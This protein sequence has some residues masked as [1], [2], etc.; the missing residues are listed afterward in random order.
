[1]TELSG[2]QKVRNCDRLVAAWARSPGAETAAPCVAGVASLL[3][4]VSGVAL[5]AGVDGVGAGD[6]RFDGSGLLGP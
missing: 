1:M 4:E 6:D 3:T 2:R 5:R